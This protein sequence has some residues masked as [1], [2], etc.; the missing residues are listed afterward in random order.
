MAKKKPFHRT[1]RTRIVRI[2]KPAKKRYLVA[3]KRLDNFLKRRPHRSFR[4]TKPRDMPK[5]APLPSNIFFTVEVFGLMRKYKKAYISFVL[6]YVVMYTLLGGISSQEGYQSLRE[7]IKAF[8]PDVVGGEIGQATQTFTLFGAAITGALN[9]PLSEAQQVY[10][11]IL[12]IFT[13]LTIVWYLRHVLAGAK[14]NVRDALYNSGS[15]FLST[16]ALACILLIQSIPA[17][18][19]VVVYFTLISSGVVQDGIESMMFAVAALLFVVLSLYWMTSTLFALVIVTLPGTYP[20]RALSLASDVVI[21]RRLSLL[22]RSIWMIFVLFLV[23][24]FILV[25]VILLVDFIPWDWLPV[26]PFVIQLLTA[27]SFLF[28]ATYAYLLYRRMINEPTVKA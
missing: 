1:L 17:V 14:V 2:L 6:I 18:A 22:V 12:G 23:W 16:A 10:I 9:D 11:G 27:W 28:F 19:A 15:P 7:G 5:L 25:P 26:V 13:W 8:G 21:G 20:M 4:Q 3:Q 24:A